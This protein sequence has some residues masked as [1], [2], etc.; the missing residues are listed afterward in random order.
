M[1]YEYY[2][3]RKSVGKCVCV[4]GKN[5]KEKKKRTDWAMYCGEIPGN[6]IIKIRM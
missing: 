5:Q 2:N 4:Y 3:K 1:P 6:N